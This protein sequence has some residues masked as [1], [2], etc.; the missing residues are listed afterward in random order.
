MAINLNRP[1][2]TYENIALFQSSSPAYSTFTNSGRALSYLPLVQSFSFGFDQNR[3]NSSALGSK[4]FI[5]QSV[6]QNPDINISIDVIEDFGK[7]FS[8]LVE[9]NHYY[10]NEKLKIRKNLNNDMNLYAM[11]GSHRSLDVATSTGSAIGFGNCLLNGLRMSQSVNGA[12]TSQYSFVANNVEAQ[13]LR[14][15]TIKSMFT[16]RNP[17]LS[18]GQDFLISTS[19]G[20]DYQ[21][22][23]VAFTGI[24]TYISSNTGQIMP[25]YNTTITINSSENPNDKEII[26]FKDDQIQN[27]E[28]DL[29]I[30]RKTIRT[31]GLNH[32][33]SRK[34]ILP[35]QGTFGFNNLI[36]EIEGGNLRNDLQLD[37]NYDIDISFK[38]NSYESNTQ[39][40]SSLNN[41]NLQIKKA[42]LNN[43]SFTSAFGG[44]SNTDTSF[45]FALNNFN[46][47]TFPEYCLTGIAHG[48]GIEKLNGNY[49]GAA[50][51]IKREVDNKFFNAGAV[52]YFDDENKISRDSPIEVLSGSRANTLGGFMDEEPSADGNI[53]WWYDQFGTINLSGSGIARYP[54]IYKEGVLYDGVRIENTTRGGGSTSAET[55]GTSFQFKGNIGGDGYRDAVFSENIS[56]IM[57]IHSPATASERINAFM[58]TYTGGASDYIFFDH[59]GLNN[60]DYQLSIDGNIGSV[61]SYFSD[62]IQNNRVNAGSEKHFDGNLMTGVFHEHSIFYDTLNYGFKVLGAFAGGDTHYF[63]NLTIK[64]LIMASG[65]QISG[66]YEKYQTGIMNRYGPSIQI[67]RNLAP[68]ETNRTAAKL[69]VSGDYVTIKDIH[70]NVSDSDGHTSYEAR[71]QIEILDTGYDGINQAFNVSSIFDERHREL[72]DRKGHIDLGFNIPAG[73]NLSPNISVNGARLQVSGAGTS[74]GRMVISDWDGT[75]PVISIGF[76]TLSS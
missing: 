23:N 65:S 42:K 72:V 37:K 6:Q 43:R 44:R 8:N 20:N 13:N 73:D 34:A 54:K 29:P 9:K 5:N 18:T 12:L 7:L 47:E 17:A 63:G 49:T 45:S 21:L 61:G 24:S 22:N 19:S 10:A 31:L 35:S 39:H 15:G 56:A 59:T 70:D 52:I 28:L 57:K 46:V 33:L 68:F 74:A 62:G 4:T 2:I 32:P 16:G 66:Q 3:T 26:L 71:D 1:T 36:S 67:F 27:F 53:V 64:Q 40:P 55:L 14:T 25:S 50:M 38:D 41:V 76:S 60:A 48:Y 69:E 30:T 11:L 75:S 51:E 58:G